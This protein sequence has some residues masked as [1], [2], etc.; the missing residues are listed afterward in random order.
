MRTGT[1][2]LG[3]TISSLQHISRE[4]T[5]MGQGMS[6]LV[7]T[8]PNF[9]G[10]SR[11]G[12]LGVRPPLFLDQNEVLRPDRPSPLISGSGRPP[13]P[14]YLKVWIRHWILMSFFNIYRYLSRSLKFVHMVAR[15]F[16]FK[17]YILGYVARMVRYEVP[18]KPQTE[19]GGV[20]EEGES[21]SSHSF[22]NFQCSTLYQ[23]TLLESLTDETV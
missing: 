10:R 23:L 8:S 6:N 20:G 9:S 19:N 3:A 21:H 16:F 12:A 18:N 15:M 4:S 17:V 14:P 13:P 11:G 2:L 1:D 5:K 7:I 22:L